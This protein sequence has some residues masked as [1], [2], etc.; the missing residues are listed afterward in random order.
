MTKKILA[1]ILATLMLVCLVPTMVFADSTTTIQV[2]TW[3]GTS[4][5]EP[6]G[7]YTSIDSAASA[8]G[9]HG[10]I[11]LGAGE[12]YFNSRQTIAV[13]QITLVGAVNADG[14]IATR[15]I[16]GPNYASSSQTNRKALLTIT[17]DGVTVENIAF[18]GGTYGSTL[19]PAYGDADT[20]FSV[21]RL[22]G[23]ATTFNNVS[24]EQS[25]RT[26]LTI[27]TSSNTAS[28]VANNFVCEGNYKAVPEVANWN[29][30]ADVDVE[31]G[32]LTVNSGAI[33]AYVQC[34]NKGTATLPAY[35]YN[36][37][38]EFLTIIPLVNIDTT[39]KHFVES[40]N[41]IK[42]TAS[43]TAVTTFK[44][45]VCDSL[46]SGEAIALIVSDISA[47]TMPSTV[48]SENTIRG[49]I[50]L[51]T[52]AKTEASIFEEETID[53]FITELQKKLPA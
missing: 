28:L 40:Y 50:T 2:A 10:K 25:E 49:L 7:N 48:F 21:V 24:I 37:H 4:Y 36:F 42:D 13:D 45:L 20:E 14:S 29:V 23:G 9:V 18:D 43:S 22:N 53:D 46:D 33:N 3:N 52:D 11:I 8:A 51:L 27:G 26:L 16:T 47:T 39:A 15:I 34:S 17:A 12:Y 44:K 32:S 31:K 5:S 30:F 6:S 19:V 1:A 41:E 35:H 38:R